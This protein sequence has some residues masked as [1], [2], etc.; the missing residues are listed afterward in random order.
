MIVLLTQWVHRGE[1]TDGGIVMPCAVI[2]E[3]QPVHRVVLLPVVLKLL[4]ALT[5]TDTGHASIRVVVRVLLDVSIPLSY[6]P[7]REMTRN[8][9]IPSPWERVGVRFFIPSICCIYMFRDASSFIFSYYS[10]HR[11]DTL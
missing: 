7:Q 5:C 2:I 1:L 6:L 8:N 3:I 9:G 4:F 10:I 11:N